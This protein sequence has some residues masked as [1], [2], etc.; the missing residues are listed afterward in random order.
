MCF[1]QR[2]YMVMW[3][4]WLHSDHS[5][6][7]QGIDPKGIW[8]HSTTIREHSS[9]GLANCPLYKV[10]FLLGFKQ[11]AR[12]DKEQ[13]RKFTFVERIVVVLGPI[14]QG[15]TLCYNMCKVFTLESPHWMNTMSRMVLCGSMIIRVVSNFVIMPPPLTNACV[16]HLLIVLHMCIS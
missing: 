7:I 14:L 13:Y 5:I 3:N 8:K 15:W 4:N 2:S 11:I 16:A 9:T 10:A 6:G 1:A 12:L